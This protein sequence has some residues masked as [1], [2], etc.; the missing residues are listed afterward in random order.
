MH[1][2]QALIEDKEGVWGRGGWGQGS[3]SWGS[4]GTGRSQGQLPRHMICELTRDPELRRV[5]HL[6]QCS[7]AIVLKSFPILSK[8]S[9]TFILHWSHQLCS[10]SWERISRFSIKQ[11]LRQKQT[12]YHIAEEHTPEKQHRACKG[13]TQEKRTWERHS[14][15][16]SQWEGN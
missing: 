5:L 12:C 15:A 16:A 8:V 1:R 11:S 4:A 6:V 14:A 13:P 9:H 7:A 2:R 3:R 10:Q